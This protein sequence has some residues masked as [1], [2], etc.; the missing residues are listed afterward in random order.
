MNSASMTA[1]PAAA[2]DT[3]TSFGADLPCWPTFAPDERAAVDA[4]LASGRVNYW[5]GTECR[6]FESEYASYLGLPR[7]IALANGTVALE[8]ALR[9]WEIAPDDEV[10]VT[11]RSFIASASCAALLGARPVFA[12]VDR[13]S[14]NISAQTMEPLVT[15][16]TRA[17]IVVHLAG[18]PCDMDPILSLADAH[19]IKVLEDCAQAHGAR[20]KGSPVGSIGHA[21]AFSFCQDKIIT[22]GGEGGLLAFR[23]GT[24]WESAWSFKDHGKA[25]EAVYERRHG[26]GFRWVHEGFG[27]NWRMT[28]MQGAIGRT[29]L[30][31]LDGWV[32]ARR[33]N[34]AVLTSR[35]G[36]LAALRVPS[37]PAEAYHAY[38]KFHFYVRPER[39]KSGW[40][41]DRLL[42]SI[43]ETGVPCFTG[44]CSE[45]YRE[46]AF[47]S[48]PWAVQ[49]RLPI[50]AELGETSLMLLVHPTL[51]EKHMHQMCDIVESVIKRATA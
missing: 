7:S 41:R 44:S 27:T 30:R 39:L 42:A 25:W 20:Y 29:Q 17:I 21:G 14:G 23:E 47:E 9:V 51:E 40:S 1:F 22:T 11:P 10:I 5:T 13:D 3:A 37:V 28:E 8:L 49:R 19:G 18:W 36:A 43:Q 46:R 15:R 50:A 33:R 32:E 4:V 6:L 38:Y 45:I 48:S 35:L 26:P 12:D 16:R 31:K 24:F 34:A 2:R